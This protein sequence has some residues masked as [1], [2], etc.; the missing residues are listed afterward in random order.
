MTRSIC[1]VSRTPCETSKLPGAIYAK[2]GR[3]IF[4]IKTFCYKEPDL[5]PIT[6]PGGINSRAQLFP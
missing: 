2:S 4:D 5:R 1:N 6:M 3:A